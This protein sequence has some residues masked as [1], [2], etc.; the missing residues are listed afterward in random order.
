M[1]FKKFI[2]LIIIAGIGIGG[3]IFYKTYPNKVMEYID[4][5]PY[6][7]KIFQANNS[8]EEDKVYVDSVA[9]I[10]GIT[11]GNESVQRYTGVV[12][13]QKMV[14]VKTEAEREVKQC[15]VEEGDHV[16]EGDALFVYDVASE[17][18]KLAQAQID[19]ERLNFDIE[20]LQKSIETY[21]NNIKT[22]ETK[23]EV[24]SLNTDILEAQTQ[25][26]QAG[27]DIQS[28]ELEIQGLKDSIENSEVSSD[29]SGKIM[30]ISSGS[31]TT[32]ASS[33]DNQDDSYIKI[34]IDGDLRIKGYINEQNKS[35]IHIGQDML[36]RARNRDATIWRGTVEEINLENG[37]SNDSGFGG[38]GGGY[39]NGTNTTNYPFY[40]ALDNSD[41]LTIGQ[42][43]YIESDIGQEEQK[44]GI[45]IDDFYIV[46]PEENPFVWASNE[47]DRLEKRYIELG[48]HDESLFKYEIKSGLSEFDY[49]VYPLDELKEGL[50]TSKNSSSSDA[51]ESLYANYNTDYETEFDYGEW[52]YDTESH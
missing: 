30:S 13:A 52:E 29:V 42:H 36:V 50:P 49:I 16:E 4:K 9:V 15:Y 8:K 41:G 47:N 46:S 20:A 23:E 22:A 24:A 51:D 45:W 14:G 48:E 2:P 32:T 27:Y 40:I 31:N 35:N 7:N 10:A 26:Q 34:M 3:F 5:I 12:E 33:Y 39:D 18:D 25:I 11:T 43:V 44:D 17:Q 37:T 38:Y 6:I 28:K 19:L 21:Q 1:S